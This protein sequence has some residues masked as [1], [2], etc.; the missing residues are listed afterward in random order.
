[1]IQSKN[2]AKNFANLVTVARGFETFRLNFWSKIYL[3]R[4]IYYFG[5][6]STFI[7]HNIDI[8]NKHVA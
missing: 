1:M 3:D 8:L 7:I 5:V 2:L 4:L 6:R